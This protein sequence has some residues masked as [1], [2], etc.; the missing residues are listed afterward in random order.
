MMSLGCVDLI[1][2]H[3]CDQPPQFDILF[4]H[5]YTPTIPTSA[6]PGK[7]LDTTM[8]DITPTTTPHHYTPVSLTLSPSLTQFNQYYRYHH[9]YP[10]HHMHHHHHHHHHISDIT[11]TTPTPTTTTTIIPNPKS[12]PAPCTHPPPPP[13]H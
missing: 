7:T 5:H 9:L 13:P 6:T 12:Q 1:P 3:Y 8:N 2:L 4:H 10:W 11:T